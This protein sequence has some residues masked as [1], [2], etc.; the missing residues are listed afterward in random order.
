VSEFAA[1]Y[2]A[3]AARWDSWSGDVMPDVRAA[4]AR[5][6]EVVVSDG[7][8]VVELGCGTGVPVAQWLAARFEYTG[9]DASE[10]MLRIARR[11]VPGGTFVHADMETA[12]FEPGSLGAVLSFYAIIHVPREQHAALFAAIASWLRP[13][14]LFVAS[15]HSRDEADDFEPDWLG[16]GPM[17]WS[18]YDR[19]TNLELIAAAG[20]EVTESEVID[21]VEPDGRAIHPLW[22]VARKPH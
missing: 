8:R 14:G 1:T 6:I 9:V 20:L 4:W 12:S 22:L 16:A 17:R 11:H 15:L 18:G 10:G 2:D 13:G 21:Q 19:D 7:E 5:Q 3:L